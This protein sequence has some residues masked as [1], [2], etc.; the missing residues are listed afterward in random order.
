MPCLRESPLAEL[1]AVL[2]TSG[3]LLSDTLIEMVWLH[4]QA[5]NTFEAQVAASLAGTSESTKH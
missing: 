5:M 2:G 1:R 4:A 3:E